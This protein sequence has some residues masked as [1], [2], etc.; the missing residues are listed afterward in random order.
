MTKLAIPPIVVIPRH[1]QN[2]NVPVAQPLRIEI[3]LLPRLRRAAPRHEIAHHDHERRSIVHDPRHHAASL[4]VV[5]FAPR[6]DLHRALQIADDGEMSLGGQLRRKIGE[7][8]S[9]VRL[10]SE[11]GGRNTHAGKSAGKSGS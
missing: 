1:G 6:F 2:R 11:R 8:R 7:A 9:A 3:E 10:A 4:R 5:V